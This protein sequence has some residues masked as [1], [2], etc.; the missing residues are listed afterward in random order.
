ML[1]RL[2]L[3]FICINMA[4][5]TIMLSVILGTVIHF[6]QANLESQSIDMMHRVVTE[7]GPPKRPGVPKPQIQLPYF[8]LRPDGNGRFTTVNNSHYDLSDEDFLKTLFEIATASDKPVGVIPEYNLRFCRDNSPRGN[9]IVFADMSAENSMLSNLLRNCC[10]IGSTSFLIFLAISILLARWAIKPVEKAWQ[11]QRQF[12]ADASH[13]LKTPL[14]VITTNAELLQSPGCDDS[15]RSKYSES[16]LVMSRQMRGLVESL[17]ELARIDNGAVRT[18][19]SL[20]DFSQL[21]QDA[22]LPFDAVFFER[23][24]LLESEI[25]PGI[26]VKGSQNHLRQVV[27]ILLDNA[28]KYST[29]GG[30]VN[31]TLSQPC[32]CHCLLRVS[33]PGEAISKEDQ[34]RIFKRFYRADKARSMNHSYG[35]GLSIAQS[36]VDDHHG[37]IWCKSSRGINTFS[38]QIPTL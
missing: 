6:T 21:T 4:I 2:R 7:L 19:F 38:V 34:R 15:G 3:K 31:L 5:V 22:V 8:I 13:E 17:L 9:R 1:K 11:Q 23:G 28:Q 12:V 37:K 16:I 20:V 35:L 25:Q 30:Q 26:R 24:L 10:L 14:T 27:E 32:R 36:I 33:N 18:T 29:P